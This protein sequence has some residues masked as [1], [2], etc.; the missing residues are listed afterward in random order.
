VAACWRVPL[1]DLAW[2]CRLGVSSHSASAQTVCTGTLSVTQTDI[3]CVV[4]ANIVVTGATDTT[5]TVN[6]AAQGFVDNLGGQS[7]H[8]P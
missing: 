7:D 6:A 1:L 4:G 3:E 2:R 8:K 5:T